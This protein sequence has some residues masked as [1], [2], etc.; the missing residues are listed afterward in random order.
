MAIGYSAGTSQTTGGAN[1]LIGEGAAQNL[2]TGGANVIIG[3]GAARS[4]T[5][6]GDTNVYVGG[7]AGAFNS[8]GSNNIGIGYAA[9][10][11]FDT[12]SHNLAIGKDALGGAVA[13]GE[14]NTG[15]GNTTLDALTSADSCVAVGHGAGSAVTTGHNNTFIGTT[16]GDAVTTSGNN[17]IIGTASDHAAAGGVDGAVVIGFNVIAASSGTRYITL[18]YQGDLTYIA[19][20]SSSWSGTSDLRLK[21]NI[22]DH[23]LGLDFVN[24]LRPVTY[25]WK[26]EKD[27][28]ESLHYYKEDSDKRVNSDDEE[29]IL[30]HGFIAQEVK[31]IIDDNN[32]DSNCFG[33]W[34]KQDDG[35]QGLAEGELT[36]I[37]VKAVQ[38]L[39]A[40]VTTLQQE[41]KTIKGE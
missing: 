9:L 32:L 5:L 25:N 4:G 15:I 11:G 18:G 8:S 14:F 33:L 12:E 38:E 35:T 3:K 37:L 10:D 22:N 41:L 34:S 20:G 1:V 24:D 36:P 19:P 28:D 29:I 17:V 21:E 13:G 39:S 40:Q 7:E 31:Q 6:T 27:V 30:K 23:T 26:K 2:T 16:A